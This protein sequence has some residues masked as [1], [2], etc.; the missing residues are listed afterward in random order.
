MFSPTTAT[1][2]PISPST[3]S[4]RF[5]R[6]DAIATFAA[7]S[8]SQSFH[9]VQLGA[10]GASPD[11]RDFRPGP[12]HQR[13]LLRLPARDFRLHRGG[14]RAGRSAIPAVI[15]AGKLSA[16]RWDGFWRCMDTFK[17]KITYDRMEARGDCPWM[18]WRKPAC[19][20]APEATPNAAAV[21][22]G[23]AGRQRLNILCLGA[24]CDDVDIGCG[25]ALLALLDR[26]RP[27]DVTW[28][29]FSAHGER[30]LEL[31]PVGGA[32]WQG[33]CLASRH[34]RLPGG[35]CG[36]FH[37]HQGGLRVAQGPAGAECDLQ[38]SPRRPASGSSTDRRAHLE[39]LPQSPDSRVRGPQVRGRPHDPL[40]LRRAHVRARER[41]IRILL[42]CYRTQR[43]KH[44]FTADTFRALM[45]LR[46]IES[47]AESGWAEGFH[48]SKILLT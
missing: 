18:V 28:V 15:A 1:A 38:S 2:S 42:E 14:R 29:I 22:P 35:P 31:R 21:D 13:R 16:F 34:A 6:G 9:A 5:S 3:G 11:G 4:C 47:G 43:R 40:R 19:R 48:A 33:G 7:V 27:A 37:G 20:G 36:R 24:H 44:W 23:A 45:R 41:K 46:G 32:F 39:H 8:N 12:A 30:E 25:G 10:N 17:D 26:H